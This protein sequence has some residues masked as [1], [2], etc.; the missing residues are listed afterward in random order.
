MYI[1]RSHF[2]RDG[3]VVNSPI[4]FSDIKQLSKRWKSLE[5]YSRVSSSNCLLSSSLLTSKYTALPRLPTTRNLCMSRKAAAPRSVTNLC[6]RGSLTD[7]SIFFSDI[8]QESNRW[9]SLE[10][11]P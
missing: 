4:F 10:R 1:A 5:R 11:Y 2:D 7:S 9:N 8:R 6:A 3:S